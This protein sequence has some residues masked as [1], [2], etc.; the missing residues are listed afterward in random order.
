MDV[1]STFL[2]VPEKLDTICGKGRLLVVYGYH[3][4]V[5][6]GIHMELVIKGGC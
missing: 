3:V 4:D 2:F 6:E 5:A 1:S